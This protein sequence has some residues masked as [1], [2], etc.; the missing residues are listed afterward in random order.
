[1]LDVDVSDVGTGISVSPATRFPHQSGDA[2]QALGGGITLDRPLSKN[3]AYGAAV[4]NS[5]AA[6]PG[7]QGPPAPNLWYGAALSARAGSIALVDASGEVIVDAVVYGSQQSSSSANGTIASPEIATLEGVQTKG[8]C[9]VVVPNVGGRGRGRG[10]GTA[11]AG[12]PAPSRSVGR[13]ADGADAD[14]NCTDFQLQSPTPG[15]PNQP[16]Q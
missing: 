11:A 10:R 14:S 1:M 13:I 16:A 9:I 12:A 7:Y 15:A 4:V 8:G 3:H 2:V 6:A 5:Q